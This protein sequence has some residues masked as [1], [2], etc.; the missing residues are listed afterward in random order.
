MLRP[1]V[2]S[3]ASIVASAGAVI[4]QP[5]ID[6]GVDGDGTGFVEIYDDH[7]VVR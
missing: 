5:M 7:C 3:V 6:A 1:V 4:P 2:G